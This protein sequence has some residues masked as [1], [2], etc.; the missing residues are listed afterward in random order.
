MLAAFAFTVVVGK[1]FSAK[2]FRLMA[3]PVFPNNISIYLM[4]NLRRS[5]IVIKSTPATQFLSHGIADNT[6]R[7]TRGD[8]VC[9]R[10]LQITLR[11]LIEEVA[12][13]IAIVSES[14]EGDEKINSIIEEYENLLDF[15]FEEE[16]LPET[17][18]NEKLFTSLSMIVL[19]FA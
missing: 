6:I 17:I 1:H 9:Q 4:D 3:S 10:T 2:T 15:L 5:N 11:I 7:L 14:S 13:K 12:K 18:H 8:Y 19:L 16:R